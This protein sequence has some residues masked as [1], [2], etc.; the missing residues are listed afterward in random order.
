ML[1]CSSSSCFFSLSLLSLFLS[2]PNLVWCQTTRLGNADRE[3]KKE[4][5]MR[6]DGFLSLF[7]LP[8]L[9]LLSRVLII[10]R[11]C[12]TSLN[13]ALPCLVRFLPASVCLRAPLQGLTIIRSTETHTHTCT[14]LVCWATQ[15]YA[16]ASA[17]TG[18]V[19]RTNL[20][21]LQH[22]QFN[23]VRAALYIHEHTLSKKQR[24]FRW[25]IFYMFLMCIHTTELL[26]A[27]T[28]QKTIGM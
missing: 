20:L 26:F 4:E 16:N 13:K 14:H 1:C 25:M 19:T 9:L 2:V 27:G 15:H 11:F 12:V 23:Q 17:N 24:G 10:T 6:K 18:R 22:N 21:P 7:S 3:V 5:E 8:H 28:V